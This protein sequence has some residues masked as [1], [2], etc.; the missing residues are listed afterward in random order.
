MTNEAND[1]DCQEIEQFIYF[2]SVSLSLSVRLFLDSIA[3]GDVRSIGRI[4][5]DN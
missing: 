5:D 1:I 3:I 4:E 2:L